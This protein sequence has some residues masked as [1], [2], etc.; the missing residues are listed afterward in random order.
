MCL[1]SQSQN[2][3]NADKT[4][5]SH[6]GEVYSA[7]ANI[8]AAFTLNPKGIQNYLIFLWTII[9]SHSSIFDF[10]ATVGLIWI[11]AFLFLVFP[12]CVLIGVE[13]DKTLNRFCVLTVR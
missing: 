11:K 10:G 4:Q 12:V 5:L 9:E 7:L 3:K 8:R 1:L 6:L 13:S 2:I